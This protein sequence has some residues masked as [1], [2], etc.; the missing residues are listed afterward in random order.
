MIIT[1]ET[2][3]TTRMCHHCVTVKKK[4][5]AK[6]TTMKRMTLGY[7]RFQRLIERGR[8]DLTTD[9]TI[10]PHYDISVP[11]LTDALQ[12]SDSRHP[13]LNIGMKMARVQY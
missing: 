5:I 6:K 2:N 8:I 4:V 3:T 10:Q 9:Q 12:T 11:H 7:R 13:V 1:E